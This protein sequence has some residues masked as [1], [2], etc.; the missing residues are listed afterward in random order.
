MLHIH[1]AEHIILVIRQRVRLANPF[2]LPE[3]S[4]GRESQSGRI[5]RVRAQVI[6]CY[7]E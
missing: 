7:D 6:A 2:F 1:D 3:A 5:E 4:L